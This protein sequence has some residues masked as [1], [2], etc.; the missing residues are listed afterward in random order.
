MIKCL[1]IGV[2]KDGTGWGN[3]AQN[4]ILA[5]DKVGIDVVPRSVK[6][7]Q[8]SDD[9]VPHIPKRILELEENDESGCDVCIQHILP[10]LLEYDGRFD[11]NIGMYAYETTNFHQTCWANHLNMMDQVWVFNHSM[12]DSAINSYVTTPI[13]VVPHCFDMSRYSQR[14]EPYPIPATQGKF[15]FYTMGEITRRKNLAGLLKAFHLE[16]SPE[17]PVCLLIKGHVMGMSPSDSSQHIKGI[18]EEVKKGMR[19]YPDATDYHNEILINQWLNDEE[20]MRLHQTG[21]CFV[22]PSYGEAWGIPGFEAMALGKAVILTDEGGPADYVGESE[23]GLLVPFHYEPVFIRPEEVRA[24]DI[25]TSGEKWHAVDIEALRADMRRVYADK[26]LR[27][28]LGSNGI[29]RAYEFSFD[30]VGATM[31]DLLEGI[32]EPVAY[33]QSILRKRHHDMAEMLENA[34]VQGR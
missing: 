11:L 12:I 22:L 23:S 16:F 17:E 31:K 24:P 29:D 19:I 8:T 33:P 1:Y 14:Y 26:E 27:D 13:A 30:K 20:V 4:Y 10:D 21:D 5:L 18:I 9:I 6:L 34:T 32:T 3:A 28:D 25:W 2:F 7:S 15:V